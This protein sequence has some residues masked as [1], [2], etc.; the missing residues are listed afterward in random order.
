MSAFE[1]TLSKTR[2]RFLMIGDVD[3]AGGSAC[4]EYF[5]PQ[6]PRFDAVLC[7]GPFVHRELHTNEDVAVAQGDIA[8]IISQLE[9]IVCRVLYLASE[10]DPTATLTEQRHFTP[11]SIN[12]HARRL[13][14][15]DNLYA[16]GFT[17]TSGNLS[18]PS[19]IAVAHA[20]TSADRSE[21]SDDELDG[22]EVQN[23]VTS[24]AIIEELLSGAATRQFPEDAIDVANGPANTA[25]EGCG[26]QSAG[27]EIEAA[28]VKG[29]EAASSSLP[30]SSSSS[31]SSSTTTAS[32]TTSSSTPHNPGT[33]IF[34][35]NYKYAHTLNHFLFHMSEQVQRANLR[36]CV[37][38]PTS[39]G[40]G[41]PVRLPTKFGTLNIAALG[42]L[43]LGGFYTVVELE[44]K[45]EE[46]RWDVVSISQ[47]SLKDGK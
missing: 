42:S 16:L 2:L 43:R 27:E 20:E 32:T 31:S 17:E 21:E 26:G 4:A 38:P 33:G 47:H 34:V 22:I 25:T 10:L 39:G 7:C 1:E 12:I 46:E 37:I 13:L 45:E 28:T 8:S 9:G 18:A 19:G 24:I 6:N 29:A 5:I 41:E 40:I 15:V 23:G 44:L 14:L 30:A 11:N 36:L 35:L 3:L